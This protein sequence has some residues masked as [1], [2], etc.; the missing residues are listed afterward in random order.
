MT[1]PLIFISHKHTDRAIAT[2]V[3]SFITEQSSGNVRVFQS[4]DASAMGPR[5]ARHLVTELRDALWDA[6]AVILVY[7][8]PDKDW[9]YCMWE[10]GVA[11]HPNS[12]DTRIIVLQC[13]ETAPDVFSGQVH[14]NARQETSVE[15]LVR[16]FMTDANF[17][18]RRTE[19]ITGYGESDPKV[20]AA[21]NKFFE[22]LKAVLPEGTGVEWPTHPYLQ[23]QLPNSSLKPITDAPPEQRSALA[24]ETVMAAAEISDAD[25]YSQALFGM[26]AFEPNLGLEAL[27]ATWRAACPNASDTWLDSLSDQVGRAAQGQFP[28]LKWTPM[29][30]VGDR[31]LHVPVLTRVRKVPSISCMQF[32]VYFYPFNVLE[33]T[34]V[35][36]RMVRRPDMFCKMIGPNEEADI[37]VSDLLR[38]L[39]ERRFGRVPFVDADDRLLYIAHRSMLDQYI[40]RQVTRGRTNKLDELTLADVLRDDPETGSMFRGTSAFVSLAATL[41]DAKTAMNRVRDCRDVFVTETG[42]AQEPVIGWITDVIIA[43]SELE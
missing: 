30:A 9:G 33:A 1:K 28:V 10:C 14:V 4:S 29:S 8:T 20:Q 21:S 2:V 42:S 18:P 41:G 36:T 22:D 43:T 7:T 37:K 17:L 34:P 6:S 31:G 26:A 3:R 25:K 16:E 19:P 35:P 32:D 27:H 13:A 24:R 5:I 40:A 15:R 11:T 12:P 39:D 23:L 38:E